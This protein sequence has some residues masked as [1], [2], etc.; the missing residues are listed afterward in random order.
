MSTGQMQVG[1]AVTVQASPTYCFPSWEEHLDYFGIA[2]P[3]PG[4]DLRPDLATFKALI[5]MWQVSHHF[6]AT[7]GVLADPGQ[8]ERTLASVVR[9]AAL[10]RAA[11][12][13][14]AQ[15]VEH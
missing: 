13:A 3:A 1:E 5:Y 4:V 8:T 15:T 2:Q 9:Q 10:C 7:P 11:D 6:D 14:V 12:L